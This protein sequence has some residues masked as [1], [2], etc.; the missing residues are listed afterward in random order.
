LAGPRFATKESIAMTAQIAR[1]DTEIPA[2]YATSSHALPFAPAQRIRSFLLQRDTGNLLVYAAP[3]TDADRAALAELGGVERQYLN[4]WHEAMFA[5]EGAG[6]PVFVHAADR[7]H[8]EERLTVRGSFSRRHVLDDDF[9]VVPIPGH[10]PGATAYV[11]TTAGRRLLFTGDT[12]VLK[13]GDWTAAVLD[14]SDRESYVRSL[15]L[16]RDLAFDVLV[17]WAAT[18]GRPYLVHT[19][20]DDARRRIDA[21]LARVRAGEPH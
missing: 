11:W 12:I 10:T 5:A 4:H 17:P 19:H 20:P 8:T 1:L 13:D 9:E 15:E 6:P 18:E 21:I 2:L 16:L 14:S 7:D 3:S